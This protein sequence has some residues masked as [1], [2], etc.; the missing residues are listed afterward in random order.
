VCYKEEKKERDRTGRCVK[1]KL[2]ISSLL[3]V[4]EFATSRAEGCVGLDHSATHA[5]IGSC[6]G[7]TRTSEHIGISPAEE[8]WTVAND[9]ETN[10]VTALTCNAL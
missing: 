5:G 9:I 10:L 4:N 3:Y 8:G 6:K 1:C 7:E 2:D